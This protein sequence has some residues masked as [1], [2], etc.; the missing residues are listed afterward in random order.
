M[1]RDI[2]IA[3]RSYRN[4]DENVK[5][6][7][8][9]LNRLV[10]LTRYTASGANLQPLKYGIVCT[11]EKV[12]KLHPYTRWAKALPDRKLPDDGKYPTAYIIICVDK[13][14]APNPDACGMDVGIAAQTILLGATEAGLGGCMLGNFNRNE[15]KQA[16]GLAEYLEPVL[17][18]AIGKPNEKVVITTADESGNT[19]YYRDEND[20]HYV[21]KRELGDIVVDI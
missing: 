19:G 20:I 7:R 21:P 4:F 8:E 2:V 12:R 10:D 5:I 6:G 14:I 16:D 1:L 18:L 17:L 11:E 3:N 9:E 15:V 13:R